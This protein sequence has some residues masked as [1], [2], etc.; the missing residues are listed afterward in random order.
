MSLIFSVKSPCPTAKEKNGRKIR[1]RKPRKWEKIGKNQF[2][3]EIFYVKRSFSKLHMLM[4][5]C[6]NTQKPENSHAAST[7]QAVGLVHISPPAARVNVCSWSENF[8]FWIGGLNPDLKILILGW[9]PCLT[10]FLFWLG[11]VD[12]KIRF[13]LGSGPL[14]STLPNLGPCQCMVASLTPPRGSES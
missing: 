14:S 1:L 12:W 11:I 6:S 13:R 3:I 4:L 8:R 2:S 5:F 9:G 10:N 7:R